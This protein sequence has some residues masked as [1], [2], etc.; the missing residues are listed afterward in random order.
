MPLLPTD[1][2]RLGAYTLVA[3]LSQGGMGAVYLGRHDSRDRPVAIKVIRPEF[4]QDR[5]YRA[6]FRSEVN[7]VREVPAFCTA[8]VL[9]ADPDHET[10]YLVVEYVKGPNL[11]EVVRERGPLE[12]AEL[13]NLAVGVATALAAIH[14]AGVIH[15]DLK[16]GNVL[17]AVGGLK[18]IDFGIARAVE[19]TS[20]HTRTDQMV[21]TVAYMAP[22]RFEA[23]KGQAVTPAADI[24]AW[25][26]LVAYAATGTTPFEGDS[27]MATGMRILTQP[28]ELDGLHGD[29]RALVERALDKDPLRRPGAH[30]LLR[31]LLSQSRPAAAAVPDR[32]RWLLAGLS[33]AAVVLGAGVLAVVVLIGR[34]LAGTG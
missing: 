1:P 28:P 9:D 20:A 13:V 3:R 11:D 2:V 10:P 16:P 7:R 33:A 8:A 23:R 5:E 4:I 29:L 15:R 25:G 22:E 12:G 19:L 21:G 27:P 6:R 18:V 32:R 14:G 30:D 34:V 26:V 24:F 17:F 31:V